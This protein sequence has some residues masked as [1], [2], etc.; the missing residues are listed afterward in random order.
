[1]NKVCSWQKALIV[2]FLI[3]LLAITSVGQSNP[4]D[5][6]RDRKYSNFGYLS[7]DDEIKLAGEIHRQ[8]L[9]QIRLVENPQLN[10][11]INSLGQRLVRRSLRPDIPWQF[12]VVDDESLNVFSTLGGRVYVN[13][14]SIAHLNNESQLASVIA[15][16]IGHVVARHGLEDLKRQQKFAGIGQPAGAVLGG[17]IRSDIGGTDGGLVVDGY[18]MNLRRDHKREADFLGLHNIQRAGYNTGGMVETFEILQ[19]ASQSQPDASGSTLA[20]QPPASERA[21]NTRREIDER[22]RGSDRKGVSDTAEFRRIKG[23]LPVPSNKIGHPDAADAI[24]SGNRRPGAS[25]KPIHKDT[26]PPR[27]VITSPSITR[28]ISVTATASRMTIR[29]QALDNSGVSEVIIRGVEAGLDSRGNFSAELLLSVGDNRITVTATDIHGNRATESFTIWREGAPPPVTGRYFA[30]VIGNNRY[31]HLSSTQQ[32]KT[33]INDAQEVTKLLRA[34]YG[35]EVKLLADAKRVE[36]INALNEYRRSLKPDDKLLVYYAGHGH[37][38]DET[39]KAYWIPTDGEQSSNA[40][41]IIADDVTANI[42][43]IP[44]RHILIVSDSCYSGALVRATDF[45]LSTL[46]ERERYLEKMRGGKSRLLMASGGNEPVTDGGGSGHSVFAWALLNGLRGM[47]ERVFTAEE[48]FHQYIKERVAGKS[49]QTPEY[50]P[51]RNS[52]HESGDFVFVRV[53]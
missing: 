15:V 2:S 8:F 39:K 5:K 49:D 13:T 12:Y 23:I 17:Q 9:K 7:E 4:Y 14:G 50:N 26:T 42:R 38:D 20:S 19:R 22:L 35:F 1:M 10:N 16:A 18:L 29:G 53:R 46:A 47:D 28:G 11:Y 31:P 6:F 43:A 40:N 21:A 52:G 32:L 25:D 44:A 41:W 36:I 48:L 27:I 34:N 45:R 24:A 51:L 3:C 30:L 33:A 37:F